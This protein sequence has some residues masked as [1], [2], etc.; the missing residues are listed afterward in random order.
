MIDPTVNLG[1][2]LTIG[3]IATGAFGFVWAL[4]GDTRVLAERLSAQ[5]RL[6]E[7]MQAEIKQ[8]GAVLVQVA[9]QSVRIQAIEER[10]SGQS[11]IFNER[12]LAEGKRVDELTVRVNRSFDKP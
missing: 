9:T 1:N 5:D 12:M 4:K 8:F 6:L 7:S 3:A 10:I 11:R 2:L